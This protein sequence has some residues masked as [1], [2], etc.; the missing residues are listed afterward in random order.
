M[1]LTRRTLV[2]FGGACLAVTAS[3]CSSQPACQPVY[4]DLCATD[5]GTSV[6]AGADSSSANSG[7]DVS[8]DAG[9]SVDARQTD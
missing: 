7:S 5:G 8:A 9:P 2:C 4:G 6:D 3:G 1:N